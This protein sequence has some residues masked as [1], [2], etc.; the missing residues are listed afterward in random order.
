[1]NDKLGIVSGI[2]CKI[3]G[4]GSISFLVH[5]RRG[6]Q[7]P[8]NLKDVIYVPSLS[9]R[10]EG[11]YLRFMSVRLAV[12]AGFKLIFS[13]NSEMTAEKCRLAPLSTTHIVPM[14]TVPE[15]D[16]TAA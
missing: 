10:S 12:N 7:V 14:Y 2:D 4:S 3:E 9:K 1:M 11:S 8:M 15:V 13:K 16:A 5:D 6:E